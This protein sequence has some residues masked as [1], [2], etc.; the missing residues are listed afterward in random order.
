MYLSSMYYTVNG[1][2]QIRFYDY[3]EGFMSTL[4]CL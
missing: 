4:C 2:L 1:A 3:D